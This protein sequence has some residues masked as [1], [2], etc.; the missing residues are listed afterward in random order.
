MIILTD[1]TNPSEIRKSWSSCNPN[2]L[3]E[4]NVTGSN[5]F[6]QVGNYFNKFISQPTFTC[7][8]LTIK[9]LELGVK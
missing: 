3:V 5:H 6:K 8:E 7:S 2:C 4:T 1:F 9:T